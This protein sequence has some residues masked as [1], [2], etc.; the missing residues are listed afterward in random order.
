MR[1]GLAG[2]YLANGLRE[3]SSLP[4]DAVYANRVEQLP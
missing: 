1:L 3:R 2:R 4:C